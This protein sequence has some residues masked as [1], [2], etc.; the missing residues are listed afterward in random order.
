M[1]AHPGRVAPT[2]RRTD[3]LTGRGRTLT[4]GLMS[5]TT[6]ELLG[7]VGVFLLLVAFFL[8]LFGFLPHRAR[9]YQSMNAVGAGL[10]CYS[11]Y[12]I[13][14]PPFIV[15]EGTWCIVAAVALLGRRS[16]S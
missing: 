11:S 2:A 14:F 5:I 13:D 8:N 4:V 16:K 10:S 7:S 15:L 9:S 3:R 1:R 12:L 6:A